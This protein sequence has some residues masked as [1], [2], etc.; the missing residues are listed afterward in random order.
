M[1]IEEGCV[2]SP[3]QEHGSG[4]D[5]PP[6]RIKSCDGC[7]YYGGKT[8]SVK[9]CNYYLI[10]GIRRPCPMGEGCVVRAELGASR[11]K[12]MRVKHR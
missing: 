5:R 11:R 2:F 8:H 6:E 9:C 4:T 3:E 1:V 12:A 7:D 10:T